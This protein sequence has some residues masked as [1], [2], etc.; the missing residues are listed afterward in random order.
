[1]NL[2]NSICMILVIILSFPIGCA[3]V[4]GIGALMNLISDKYKKFE[5]INSLLAMIVI[6]IIFALLSA[7]AMMLV[8]ITPI[9]LF[10]IFIL[11]VIAIVDYLI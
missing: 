10:I 8:L 3:I 6:I 4:Y 1:M 2:I 11:L 7:A 5:W 9:F